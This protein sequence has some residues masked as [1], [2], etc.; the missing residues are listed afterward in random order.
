MY[1]VDVERTNVETSVLGKSSY[2]L[3]INIH[4]NIYFHPRYLL[5]QFKNSEQHYHSATYT[6]LD[7][8]G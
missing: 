7:I 1:I 8:S 4:R 2:Y 3:S 6:K 5:R